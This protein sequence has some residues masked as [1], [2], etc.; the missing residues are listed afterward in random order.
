MYL[1]KYGAEGA[2]LKCSDTDRGLAK[3]APSTFSLHW[4]ESSVSA[5]LGQELAD[6]AGA[7]AY[8]RGTAAAKWQ[9]RQMMDEENP[10]CVRFAYQG[11]RHAT[12]SLLLEPTKPCAVRSEW[13]A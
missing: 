7:R 10:M 11:R 13:W 6:R 2:S 1:R 5:L 8:C 12:P 9:E 3:C 4:I